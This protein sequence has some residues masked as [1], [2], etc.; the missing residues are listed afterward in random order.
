MDSETK[1]FQKIY[2]MSDYINFKIYNMMAS[3]YTKDILYY[4]E[5]KNDIAFQD[6]ETKAMVTKTLTQGVKNAAILASNK[7]LPDVLTSDFRLIL[8]NE[9]LITNLTALHNIS[10]MKSSNN[11][12]LVCITYGDNLYLFQS[13]VFTNHNNYI[14]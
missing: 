11:G 2:S 13:E 14:K 4:S 3:N 8:P 7:V 1:N 5:Y 6:V 12:K 10:Y 9:N